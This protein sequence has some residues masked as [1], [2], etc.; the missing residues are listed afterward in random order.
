MFHL[1]IVICQTVCVFVRLGIT[2][3]I[4]RLSGSH[5]RK[6]APIVHMEIATVKQE[7]ALVK[8]VSR[9][10][11]FNF[12]SN[13]NFVLF[14]FV[15][16]CFFFFF[17]CYFLFSFV[18]SVM[19]GFFFCFF[20]NVEKGTDCSQLVCPGSPECNYP[21]GTCNRATA[22][23]VC[24]NNSLTTGEYYTGYHCQNKY[25]VCAGNPQCS[26]TSHG[27]CNSKTGQC[28]C[29]YPFN[30]T[31]ASDCSVA[32][33]SNDCYYHG[34]HFILF[35]SFLLFFSSFLLFFLLS[36]FLLF[37]F[38]SFLLFFFSSFLLFFSSFLFLF[39]W[40]IVFLLSKGNCDTTNGV[41]KC[42]AQYNTTSDCRYLY[43]MF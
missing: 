30:V 32:S 26:G 1:D 43:S 12:N 33:C 9:F 40:F 3:R 22:Q 10:V 19:S 13:F 35:S 8:L 6:T 31:L 21:H 17:Y 37:F 7:T 38:S 16:L 18:F 14:C 4:V 28:A 2:V 39:Q 11:T 15:L 27:T 29:K 41:C 23:C 25:Y 42:L 20:I 34:D 24:V 36:S 5:A